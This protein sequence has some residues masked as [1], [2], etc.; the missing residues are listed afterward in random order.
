MPNQ[1]GRSLQP[2]DRIDHEKGRDDRNT[3]YG[4]NDGSMGRDHVNYRGQ[5]GAQSG[6]GYDQSWR[7][8]GVRGGSEGR[9]GDMDQGGGSGHD[10][11]YGARDLKRG[12]HAGKGP[13]GFQRSDERIREMVHEALTDDHHVDASNLTV[14]VKDGEVT[15]TGTVED[16]AMKR[17][18]EDV[19]LAVKGVKDVHNQIRMA[20]SS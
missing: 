2:H 4:Y 12:P 11:E 5:S 6:G 14:E 15:L 17:R 10:P 9:W 1:N 16:R 3:G 13:Q 7:G 19:V 20:R 18:A 8:Q